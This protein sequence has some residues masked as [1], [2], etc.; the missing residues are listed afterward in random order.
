MEGGREAG[1]WER[2]E[3]NRYSDEI[4][5][6]CRPET[7]GF[8]F[9]SLLPILF[10]LRRSSHSAERS[11]RTILHYPNN[12]GSKTQKLFILSFFFFYSLALLYVYTY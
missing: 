10:T 8:G 3:F 1:G 12:S 11:Q 6:H 9:L 7:P 4:K 2:A 5:S